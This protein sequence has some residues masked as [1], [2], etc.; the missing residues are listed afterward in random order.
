MEFTGL[1]DKN[2]KEIYERD[3]EKLYDSICEVKWEVIDDG[4][5]DLGFGFQDF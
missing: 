5:A 2:G 4:G 1:L 3:F